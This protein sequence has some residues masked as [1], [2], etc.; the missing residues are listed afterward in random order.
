MNDCSPTRIA[1][2]SET[3][4]DLSFCSLSISFNFDWSVS[5]SPLDSDHCPIMIATQDSPPEPRLP[6]WN[7]KHAD[8][9][10][11]S[12]STA[13]HNLSSVDL[14]NLDLISDLYDQF[15]LA[16]EES[17]P[18]FVPS[19]FYPRPWWSDDIKASKQRRETFYQTYWRTRTIAEMVRWKRARAEHKS[20]IRTA[21]QTSWRNYVS[22]LKYGAL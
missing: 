13:W 18:K 1:D 22:D 10:N 20:K 21:K 9:H 7:L 5:R 12:T 3:A 14:N 2:N 16:C 6:S 17:I 19:K 8:W 4:I 11:L 15:D